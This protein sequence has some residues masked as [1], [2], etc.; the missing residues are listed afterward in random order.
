MY[1]LAMVSNLIDSVKR[2]VP[3]PRYP[4]FTITTEKKFDGEDT[5]I[6]VTCCMN[7]HYQWDVFTYE[8]RPMSPADLPK[9]CVNK[10]FN[11]GQLSLINEYLVAY[12]PLHLIDRSATTGY[13]P[14]P[15]DQMAHSGDMAFNPNQMAG[16][17]ANPYGHPSEMRFGD[18]PFPNQ[19]GD[20]PAGPQIG[21]PARDTYSP[22][23]T[24]QSVFGQPMP[25]ARIRIHADLALYNLMKTDTRGLY[26]KIIADLNN[27]LMA[28][29]NWTYVARD[30]SP[31]LLRQYPLGEVTPTESALIVSLLG[32]YFSKLGYTQEVTTSKD[33]F[34]LVHLSID[35]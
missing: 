26:N 5:L 31:F 30:E 10:S 24:R 2:N 22:G 25:P 29:E 4:G 12:D 19:F 27:A 1:S 20:W 14:R 23:F 3:L 18:D 15:L 33:E 16:F 13:Q 6:R 21:M 17:G 7:S 28:P 32:K 35:I 9:L 34:I 11:Q 8:N